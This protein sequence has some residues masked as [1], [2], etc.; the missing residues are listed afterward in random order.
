MDYQSRSYRRQNFRLTSQAQSF[1]TYRLRESLSRKVLK[2][3][4]LCVQFRNSNHLRIVLNRVK[5]YPFL[6]AKYQRESRVYLSRVIKNSLRLAGKRQGYSF[7]VQQD[8]DYW[9]IAKSD[10]GLNPNQNTSLSEIIAGFILSLSNDKLVSDKFKAIFYRHL[11]FE[12]DGQFYDCQSFLIDCLNVF[13][14]REIK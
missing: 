12:E 3:A 9:I 13:S 4:S 5:A 14:T 2:E 8:I 11:R 10:L 1:R 6:G 7:K